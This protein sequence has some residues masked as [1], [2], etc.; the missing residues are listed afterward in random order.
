MA[1]FL[2]NNGSKEI[3]DNTITVLTD[4]LKVMLVAVGYVA[5]RDD[6]YVDESGAN[7]P[8]DHEYDGSGYT[9]GWGGSGRKT[10]ASKTITVDKANDRSDFD[11]ADVLW[12]SIGP[13]GA[14]GDPT[15]LL[16]FEPGTS[17]DTDAR[18]IC[19]SDFS[20]TTNGGDVTAQINDLWRLSTV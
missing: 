14:A 5:D 7:D 18:L 3:H 17:D 16:T 9:G 13:A 11:A 15:Q 4:T 8:I 2:Y 6:D 12:S 1:D 19:H 10:L 20:V